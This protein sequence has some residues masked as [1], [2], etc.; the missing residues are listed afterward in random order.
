[1]LSVLYEYYVDLK[2]MD[3]AGYQVRKTWRNSGQ[4]SSASRSS[5]CID[6]L[7]GILMVMRLK[8][9]TEF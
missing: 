6:V 8:V 5:M 2:E 7:R 9:Y 1:M 4:S 3:H